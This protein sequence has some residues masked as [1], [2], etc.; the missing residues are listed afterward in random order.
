LRFNDPVLQACLLR[1]S[2]PSE[3]DYS[4]SPNLS[5]LMKEFLSKVFARSDKEFGDA[6]LEF[7]AAIAVGS[8]RLS[9]SDMETLIEENFKRIPAPSALIGLLF[10]ATNTNNQRL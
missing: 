10:M 4:A 6:A 3:L 2:L 1:A 5:K 8:L 9:R 7:A